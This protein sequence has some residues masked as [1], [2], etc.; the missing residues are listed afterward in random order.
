MGNPSASLTNQCLVCTFQPATLSVAYGKNPQI[1][2]WHEDSEEC[3]EDWID[4]INI[5]P[6]ADQKPVTSHSQSHQFV[7]SSVSKRRR[8]IVLPLYLPPEEPLCHNFRDQPWIVYLAIHSRHSKQFRTHHSPTTSHSAS[9]S[10]HT[11]EAPGSQ[12]SED[13]VMTVG[14]WV[15]DD[16]SCF[17]GGSYSSSSANCC[18]HWRVSSSSL[19]LPED[20]MHQDEEEETVSGS[21]II[22]LKE[23][24]CSPLVLYSTPPPTPDCLCW[25]RTVMVIQK[26]NTTLVP[27]LTLHKETS[28]GQP[29]WIA[30]I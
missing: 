21:T 23:I 25:K 18:L 9:G 7:R 30:T 1:L 8:E 5:H 10:T 22:I 29:Q 6:L 19:L 2:C 4:L 12:P 11:R 27:R 15:L 14:N 16:I 3:G 17:I 26:C 28:I 20:W 13:A 24:C